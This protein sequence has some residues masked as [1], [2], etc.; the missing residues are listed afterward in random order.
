MKHETTKQKAFGKQESGILREHEVRKEKL[1]KNGGSWL[2][3]QNR[4]GH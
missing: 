4:N 3:V 1:V 2:K